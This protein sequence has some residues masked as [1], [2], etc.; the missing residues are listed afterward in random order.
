MHS[1]PVPSNV[2]NTV[3]GISGRA[4]ASINIYYYRVHNIAVLGKRH[5]IAILNVSLHVSAKIAHSLAS[6]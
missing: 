1:T 5:R 4:Y 6:M 2:R 3:I